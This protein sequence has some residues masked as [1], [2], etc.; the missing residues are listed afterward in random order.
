MLGDFIDMYNMDSMVF[1]DRL[2]DVSGL[3]SGSRTVGLVPSTAIHV[4]YFKDRLAGSTQVFVE[5]S[6]RL[7]PC[8]QAFI[9]TCAGDPGAVVPAAAVDVSVGGQVVGLTAPGSPNGL[10]SGTVDF[11][12]VADGRQSISVETQYLGLVGLKVYGATAVDSE[13]VFVENTPP[14]VNTDPYL[15]DDFESYDSTDDNR[16]DV[17]RV[18]W[19][20]TGVMNALRLRNSSTDYY[21]EPGHWLNKAWSDSTLNTG[22]VL[23]V[24]YDV[25]DKDGTSDWTTEFRR[26]YPAARDWSAARS[27]AA[28]VQPDGKG[29]FLKFR[30][31]TGSGNQNT[32]DCDFST[33]GVAWGYDPTLV[34]P[35]LIQV[36]IGCFKA[37]ADGSEITTAKLANVL[38]T[39]VRITENRAKGHL[40]GLNALE[41]YL[42]DDIKVSTSAMVNLVATLQ[43]IV[44]MYANNHE[45][46][47]SNYTPE[48][49]A[50]FAAA[51]A[52]ARA[53]IATGIVSQLTFDSI[54][55]EL[56]ATSAALVENINTSALDAPIA[57]AEEILADPSGYVPTFLGD[58]AVALD[59][60]LAVRAHPVSQVQVTLEAVALWEAIA[61]VHKRGDKSLLIALVGVI[62]GLASAQFTPGSWAFVTAALDVADGV[63]ADPIAP[64]YEVDDAYEGLVVALDGLVLRAAKAGLKSALDVANQILSR[65]SLYVPSSLVGL[66]AARDLAQEVFDDQDATQA[67]VTAAQ[68]ALLAKIAVAKLK[69]TSSPSPSGLLTPQAAAALALN[70][71]G[72]AEVVAANQKAVAQGKTPT[73]PLNQTLSVAPT[74]GN[75]KGLVGASGTGSPLKAFAKTSKPKISGKPS[76]GTKLSIKLRAWAPQ[77]KLTYTWYVG[78]KLVSKKATYTI[79]PTDTGKKVKVKVTGKKTGYTTTT[80]TSTKTTIH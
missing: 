3:V 33:T 72:V 78:G 58:L 44:T 32:F 51:M 55:A 71:E 34:A 61:R 66:E 5:A 37:V 38:T 30:L 20:T 40:G 6:S 52:R 15:I 54:I 77:P 64:V 41:Y 74:K 24:K 42:F 39:S 7:A 57:V 75:T 16:T 19:R 22:K 29:H 53:A 10:W 50:P 62:R 48:S 73:T 47:E 17:E 79:K 28:R 21:T 80:K 23:R 43:T 26:T 4:P 18:W 49:F 46:N 11:G 45:A 60:A 59:S 25:V 9:G 63:I 35:Q 67:E 13:V 27:F 14:S 65:A 1:A 68:S 31:T 8:L 76:P 70:P 36:P 69:N 2:G 12:L 56:G